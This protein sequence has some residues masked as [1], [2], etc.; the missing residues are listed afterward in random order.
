MCRAMDINTIVFNKTVFGDQVCFIRKVSHSLDDTR[1]LEEIETSN[2]S[3]DEIQRYCEKFNFRKR[4]V[5]HSDSLRKSKTAKIKAGF[6][7]LLSQNTTT[8][9]NYGYYG[10]TKLK[11]F[12]NYF[13]G[14]IKKN[15]RS[16]YID[17]N[18][19]YTLEDS[20][21][22]V[23]FPLHQTPE[24]SLLIGSPFNT[25]QIEIIKHI[26]KSL[27][28]G[29]QLCVKEHPTQVIREWREPSF[30]KEISAIPNVQ[31]LHYSVKTDDI[32]KKCSLV[33]TINGAAG[34]EAAFFKKPSIVFTDFGYSI[35]PS[36]H[37][38]KSIY[39]LPNAIRL[40]L[41]KKVNVSDIDKYLNLLDAH[42]FLFDIFEFELDYHNHFFYGGHLLDTEFTE[43]QVKQ[44]AKKYESKFDILADIYIKKINRFEK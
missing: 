33:I 42:T 28:I 16:N 8:E 29:Y 15:S 11:A 40:S 18:L 27:P 7:F 21:P 41:R 23:Y 24:R 2:R 12:A 14:I 10:H 31:F 36:V 34:L 39:E 22:F 30:Y 17:K 9:N 26:S 13:V 3:F 38:L 25:N 20:V 5:H 4:V 19:S 37:K 43:E 6:N 32:M 35:L 1:S 44:F